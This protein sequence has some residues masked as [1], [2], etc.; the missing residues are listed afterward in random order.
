MAFG[1]V[2]GA[3][4]FDDGGECAAVEVE[5]GVEVEDA[6]GLLRGVGFDGGIS[7]GL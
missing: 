2:A 3:G 1:G 4:G 5:G 7:G 6:E